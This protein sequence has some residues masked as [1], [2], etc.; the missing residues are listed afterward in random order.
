MPQRTLPSIAALLL[1]PALA[2]AAP[3]AIPVEKVADAQVPA[4]LRPKGTLDY[5][6]R[7]NDKNGANYLVVASQSIEGGSGGDARSRYLYIVHGACQG[8]ACKQLRQLKDMVEKCGEDIVLEFDPES[9][10]VTDLDG[11]GLSEATFVYRLTCRGDVGPSD[12]KLMLLEN[13]EKLAAR[14]S[15]KVLVGKDA[16]GDGKMTPDPAF[17]KA[18]PAFLEHARALWK[19]RATRKLGGD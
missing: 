11:D 13:G 12:M 1:A 10:V 8:A 6:Y 4:T 3:A 17:K 16:Y 15:E 9:L 7:W 14:G 19:K 18:P 5:A 2:M